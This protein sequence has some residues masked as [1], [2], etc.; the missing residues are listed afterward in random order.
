MIRCQ[1]DGRVHICNGAHEETASDAAD[2]MCWKKWTL[3]AQRRM[4]VRRRCC[5]KALVNR[6][7]THV[8]VSE[9]AHISDGVHE[10]IVPDAADLK[11]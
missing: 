5:T 3:W 4:E 10:T 9:Y 11:Y 6:Q 2:F 8:T 7:T 1:S